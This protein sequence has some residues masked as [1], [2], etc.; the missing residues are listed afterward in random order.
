MA[1]QTN[2][3]DGTTVFP[4]PQVNW[5]VGV[6]CPHLVLRNKNAR[7]CDLNVPKARN[8]GEGSHPRSYYDL[9]SV[10]PIVSTCLWIAAAA[11]GW[12]SYPA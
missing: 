7:R 4:H 1:H 3:T 8:F 11:G 2:N 5:P 10:T 12:P 6:W 9:G